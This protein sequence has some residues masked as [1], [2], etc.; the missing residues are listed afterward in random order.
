MLEAIGAMRGVD[1]V[2]AYLPIRDEID[3]L[4][5]MLALV[6]LG[7]RVAVPVIGDRATPLSFRAWRPGVATV[8]GSYGVPVPSAGETL[9]PDVLL[10]PM[11]AFD[12]RGHRLGYGGG[13]Y[14]RTIAGLRA[15]RA[16]TALGLAYAA[17]EVP[18]VPDSTHDMQLDAIVT[19]RGTLRLETVA[20]SAVRG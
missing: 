9:T 8:R 16:V 3:P 18:E 5:S 14:D 13:F 1:V 15:A 20:G 11:L 4:P 2:A 7:F 10:V 6:G 19:E 12:R 17:Q